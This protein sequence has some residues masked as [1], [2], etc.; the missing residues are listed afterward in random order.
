MA[1]FVII[2]LIGLFLFCV[3]TWGGMG[4]L[5]FLGTLIVLGVVALCVADS[6]KS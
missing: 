5:Y 3:S 6:K 2:I 1:F 4:I